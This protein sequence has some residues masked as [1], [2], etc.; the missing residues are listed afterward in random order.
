[1]ILVGSKV[2]SEGFSQKKNQKNQSFVE[3]EANFFHKVPLKATVLRDPTKLPKKL[4]SIFDTI[5][6][7]QLL[8]TISEAVISLSLLYN[9][10]K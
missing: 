8:K 7:L 10:L 6:N 9:H 4:A 5:L 2:T 3:V 1:M